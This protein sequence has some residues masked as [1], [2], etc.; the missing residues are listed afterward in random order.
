MI[1]MISDQTIA[2]ADRPSILDNLLAGLTPSG[3]DP[4]EGF[5]VICE[6]EVDPLVDFRDELSRK[7]WTNN[8]LCQSCQDEL[9]GFESR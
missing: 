2:F 7:E 1:P 4:H 5:C 6:C 3:K 8:G 9:F